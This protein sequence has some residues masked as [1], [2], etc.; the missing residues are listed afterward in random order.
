MSSI[1][2]AIPPEIVSK[3]RAYARRNDTSLNRMIRDYL[4]ELVGPADEADALADE[5]ARL[6]AEKGIRRRRPYRFRRADA[7][8]GEALG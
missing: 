4:A 8:D 6:V 5:F 3:A 1:T 7:Y 2:L